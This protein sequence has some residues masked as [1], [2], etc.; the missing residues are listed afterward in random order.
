MSGDTLTITDDRTGKTYQIPIEDGTIRA[1]DLR[2]I[3]VADDDFGMMSYDPAYQNTA[4]CKSRITFIDGDKGI[5][6]Y[7]GYP[8]EQLAEKSNYMEVAYLIING[9]LPTKEQYKDW[10]FNITHHT[11]IHENMKKVLDGFHHDAH[12]MGMLVSTVA[13]L[14]TFYPNARRVLD[15]ENRRK[16]TYRLIAK[17]PTLAAY[18]YRHSVGMPYTPPDNELSYCG[19]LLNMMFRM[20]EPKYK[21]NPILERALDVLFILHADHEQNWQHQCH[22]K[23]GKL[24][25]RCLFSHCRRGRGSLRS[26]SWRSQ[27][28]GATY[29]VGNWERRENPGLHQEGQGR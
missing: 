1:I 23:R 8:I 24:A 6:R 15:A 21:P 17:T 20:T 3:K 9:E 10:V 22:A 18:A 5:L 2:N 19:N 13:A 4:S 28:S 12:P 7:R 25:G 16:Q 29:A 26:A 14:S 11:I 27:R